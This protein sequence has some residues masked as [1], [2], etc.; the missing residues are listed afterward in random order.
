MSKGRFFQPTRS[1]A[2]KLQQSGGIRVDVALAN[3]EAGVEKLRDASMTEINALIDRLA[4]EIARRD[5]SRLSHCYASVGEILNLSGIYREVELCAAAESLAS[6]LAVWMERRPLPHSGE[7]QSLTDLFWDAALVHAKALRT[8]HGPDLANQTEA[9]QAVVKGLR[10]AA[11]RAKPIEPP[12]E[13][14][15]ALEAHAAPT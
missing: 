11:V 7:L 15:E 2:R 10:A 13:E 8:L 12:P 3:A 14:P 4:A 1:L 9:R 6:H 5:E